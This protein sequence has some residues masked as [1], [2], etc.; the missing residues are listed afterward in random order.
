MKIGGLHIGRQIRR[1]FGVKVMNNTN[2]RAGRR[3]KAGV[4]A[5]AL[6]GLMALSMPAAAQGPERTSSETVHEENL[7]AQSAAKHHYAS[8]AQRAEDALLI[9]KIKAAIADEGLADDYPLTVDADHDRVTLVG[10]LASREDVD[11]AVAL[12]AG[13]DGVK[14]IN[15]RTHLAK[16]SWM[17]GQVSGSPGF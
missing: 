6:S 11:R 9:V 14:G 4:L 8:P 3:R 16:E 5:A 17:T 1:F 2:R 13:I 15:N 10:V 7:Q 12:V